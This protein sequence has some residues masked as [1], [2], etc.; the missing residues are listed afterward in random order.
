M[1]DVLASCTIS[2][3]VSK[4]KNMAIYYSISAI[5]ATRTAGAGMDSFGALMSISQLVLNINYGTPCMCSRCTSWIQQTPQEFRRLTSTTPKNAVIFVAF[6]SPHVKK[7][8]EQSTILHLKS[9]FGPCN[10]DVI[11]VGPSCKLNEKL[12]FKTIRTFHYQ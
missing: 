2:H 12:F 8:Q 3:I 11:F 10:L 7:P 4:T 1:V 5:T 6:N 9:V